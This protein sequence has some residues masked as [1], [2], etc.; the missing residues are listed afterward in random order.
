MLI[1]LI[2]AN[3]PWKGLSRKESGLKKES[4][5]EKELLVVILFLQDVLLVHFPRNLFL[6][7]FFLSFWHY[8][9]IIRKVKF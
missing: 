2:T 1:E 3:L 9:K 6:I 4:V 7:N 8:L 5:N